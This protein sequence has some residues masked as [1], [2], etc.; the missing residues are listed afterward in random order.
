MI[1]SNRFSRTIKNSVPVITTF[2]ALAISTP[3][4]ATLFLDASEGD[5]MQVVRAYVRQKGCMHPVNYWWNHT[6]S[7][8]GSWDYFSQVEDTHQPV[9]VVVQKAV[10][11]KFPRQMRSYGSEIIMAPGQGA[12][13]LHGVGG[14]GG[15]GAIREA[16]GNYG[17]TAHR[18][19]AHYPQAPHGQP[20]YN[21]YPGAAHSAYPHAAPRQYPG[22]APSAYPQAPSAYPQ[23]P[24]A[25]PQARPQPTS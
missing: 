1:R 24:S 19:M 12:L 6:P 25:Y 2:L 11:M 15:F 4:Q 13:S 16:L 3:A 5:D 18:G 21:A 17:P 9:P 23:A 10:E 14:P 8:E 20:G 22:M 7:K